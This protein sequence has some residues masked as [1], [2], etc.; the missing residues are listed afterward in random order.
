MYSIHEAILASFYMNPRYK[1]WLGQAKFDLDA[2]VSAAQNGFYEWACFISEQCAEKAIKSIIVANS[3][4]APKIHKLSA[5]VNIAKRADHSFAQVNFPIRE[6]GVFT[7]IARYP[8]LIPGELD[9]PHLYITL[10]DA[11][12]CIDKATKILNTIESSLKG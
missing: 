11:R 1:V 2:A 12:L 4:I 9:A 10:E 3:Q 7:F 8:F 5:L 6:L